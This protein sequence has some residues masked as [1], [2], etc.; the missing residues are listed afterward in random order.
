[1]ARVKIFWR[2]S[3]DWW[4]NCARSVR[5]HDPREAVEALRREIGALGAK[6]DGIAHASISPLAFERIRQQT[7]EA[8]NLLATLAQ[9]PAPFDR[10]ERQIGGLADR[11]YRLS[12]S[13][14][15]LV[16]SAEVVASLAEAR[17][18][19]ERSTPASALTSIERRLEQIAAKMDQALDAPAL[20]STDDRRASA[21]RPVAPHRWRARKH[22]D[23]TS[24]AVDDGARHEWVGKGDQRD[25][26]QARRGR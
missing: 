26:R 14:P 22:R 1:M 15:P 8:R 7:E 24:F 17:A 9:K 25:Q 20:P 18:L 10:L 21:R 2:L 5:A 3:M 23:P 16:V 11:V 6:V 12:F 19:V 13:P 4:R